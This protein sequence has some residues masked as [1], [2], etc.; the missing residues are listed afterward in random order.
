LFTLFF[1]AYFYVQFQKITN[2]AKEIG[3]DLNVEGPFYTPGLLAEYGEKLE[4]TLELKPT[5]DE[6]SERYA[7]HA[8]PPY[9]GEQIRFAE[10]FH[11]GVV[12]LQAGRF[13]SKEKP[14]VSFSIPHFLVVTQ[15]EIT[16]E[17]WNELAPEFGTFCQI[18]Q[19]LDIASPQCEGSCPVVGVSWLQAAEFANGLSRKMGLSTCYSITSSNV[20]W[21]D[22]GCDGWRLPTEAEWLYAANAEEW[23]LDVELMP[24]EQ[25]T[26]NGYTLVGMA[27][28]AHEWVWD[29][30]H[31]WPP[32][33]QVGYRGPERNGNRVVRGGARTGL[34]E[35]HQSNTVGFRL[36]RTMTAPETQP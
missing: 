25:S 33:E 21:L 31:D 9:D 26:K 8:E 3:W 22:Q 17:L 10:S 6:L 24:I 13:V 30:H 19:C 14:D 35:D 18:S 5:V 29:V 15:S 34:A 20:N 7:F 28:N 36:V 4:M 1:Q 2:S 32:G 11:K 27:D 23:P 16:V 12:V